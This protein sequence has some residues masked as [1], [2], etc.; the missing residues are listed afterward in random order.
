MLA[1]SAYPLR[2]GNF[3]THPLRK[4]APSLIPLL[5]THIRT[6]MHVLDIGCLADVTHFFPAQQVG[7]SG[8][9]TCVTPHERLGKSVKKR[10]KRAR[11]LDRIS[12]YTCSYSALGLDHLNGHI[13]F[14][15]VSASAATPRD[16]E[17]LFTELFGLIKP[18]RNCLW[19]ERQKHISMPEQQNLLYTA[20]NCGFVALDTPQ[21]PQCHMMLLRR[22]GLTS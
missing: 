8:H 7:E 13:D 10:A 12:V 22:A 21:H 19:I 18:G 17:T 6:G 2:V 20:E 3:S 11:M 1:K 15:L 9:L 5:E 16:P 14:C 4:T